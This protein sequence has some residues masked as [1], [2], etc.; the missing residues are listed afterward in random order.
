M[1]LCPLLKS[2]EKSK[3]E[4]TSKPVLAVPVCQFAI[5]AAPF[6]M[7]LASKDLGWYMLAGSFGIAPSYIDKKKRQN[8]SSKNNRANKS[9]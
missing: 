2:C 5:Y 6:M 3:I 1:F 9:T 4:I 7:F 8:W